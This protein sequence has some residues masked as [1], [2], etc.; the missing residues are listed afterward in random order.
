MLVSSVFKKGYLH[1]DQVIGV[2]R[3]SKILRSAVL[4]GRS[5]VSG[6]RAR[7]LRSGADAVLEKPFGLEAL[8]KVVLPWTSRRRAKARAASPLRGGTGFQA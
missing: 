4:I 8:R 2:F 1:G 7:M 6:A 3:N 5:G